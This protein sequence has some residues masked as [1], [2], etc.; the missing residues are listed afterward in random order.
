MFRWRFLAPVFIALLVLL[1]ICIALFVLHDGDVH[2]GGGGQ[3]NGHGA[4]AQF[5]YSPNS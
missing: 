3:S 1:M 2:H 4:S 5:D